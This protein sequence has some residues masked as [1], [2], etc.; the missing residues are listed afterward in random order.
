LINSLNQQIDTLNREKK[1]IE[2]QL[3]IEKAKTENDAKKFQSLL[4]E[5][6]KEK[7][8]QNKNQKIYQ[9]Q[10]SHDLNNSSPKIL[11]NLDFPSLYDSARQN[12]DFS[13]SN[14]SGAINVLESLQSKLKQKDGEIVQ[15]QKEIKNLEK[16]RESMAREMV[17]L[18]DS[19]EK[20]RDQ[21]KEFPELQDKYNVRI[22]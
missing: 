17:N 12:T 16:I 6:T 2:S 8:Q 3:D 18:T 19:L 15:L 10:M 11:K 20:A 22:N 9:E 4:N 5:Y 13:F 1:Y 21:I 14:N 7:E